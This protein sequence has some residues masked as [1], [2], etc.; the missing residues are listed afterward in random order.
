MASI[1]TIASQKG[2]AGKTTICRVLAPTLARRGLRVACVDADPNRG[3]ADWHGLYTGPA[4]TLRAEA[5]E[6]TLARL[7]AELAETHDVVLVDTAGFGSRSMV[8][9][10]G[11]ADAVLI[12]CQPDRSSVREAQATAEWCVNLAASVRREI[13]FR[14]TL[15]GFDPRRATDTFAKTQL[16]EDLKLPLLAA[17]LS[18]RTA[19][20]GLSWSGIMPTSGPVWREAEALADELAQIG[21][22]SAASLHTIES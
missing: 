4:I 16:A 18:D 1:I 12:P 9:A 6:R 17:F 22:I 8:V 5:D 19:Y 11:G 2:G 10:I 21:W 14:I 7:P 20:Q 13:S 15:V 3:L